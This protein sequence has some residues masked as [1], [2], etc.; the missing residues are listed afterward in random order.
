MVKATEPEYIVDS[1]GHKTKVILPVEAYEELLAAAQRLS[2]K[3]PQTRR[4]FSSLGA[5]EDAALQ[6]SEAHELIRQAW[7]R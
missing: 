7:G 2:E 1:K 6:G 5:G 4:T 3:T